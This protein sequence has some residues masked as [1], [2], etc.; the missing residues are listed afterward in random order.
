M[1]VEIANR[2]SSPLESSLDT[3]F[4]TTAWTFKALSDPSR[5][6]ILVHL[7]QQDASCCA[8]GEGVCACDLESVTGLSQPTVS[9]H[10]KC[11]VSAGLVTGDKRGK[12]MYYRVN[13]AGF[14]LVRAALPTLGG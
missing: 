14:D 10:M 13:P 1:T 6:K 11:L 8:P 7:A 2:P 3:S 12:W 9:H 5:L 4:D